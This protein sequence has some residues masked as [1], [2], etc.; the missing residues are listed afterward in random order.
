MLLA[1]ADML[2]A[3]VAAADV[4]ER[5]G[6]VVDVVVDPPE[7]TVLAFLVRPPGLFVRSQF[8]SPHDVVEYDPHALIVSAADTL[9]PTNEIVR[10]NTLLHANHRVIGRAVIAESG[11][12]IGS[13][14]NFAIDTD[15]AGIVRYY[16]KSRF[17][18]ERIIPTTAIIEVT[19]TTFVIRDE[20]TTN[21][22]RG[23]ARPLE[24][25]A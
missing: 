14:I 25:T 20:R 6:T 21:R 13:V 16:V 3:P 10:A 1:Y 23:Q 11:T 9:V 17:G 24:K 5:I 8:V 2:H 7:H 12:K 18:H 19:A 22:V 15:T 4:G